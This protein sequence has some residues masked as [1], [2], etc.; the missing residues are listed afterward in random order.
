MKLT[1][2]EILN[3]FEIYLLQI[4]EEEI[5]DEYLY[6]ADGNKSRKLPNPKRMR[7]LVL[8]RIKQK[9]GNDGI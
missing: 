2:D 4:T 7:E 6:P 3:W 8:E 9:R 5:R 1:I